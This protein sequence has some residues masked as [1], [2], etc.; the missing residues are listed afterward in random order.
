MFESTTNCY[1]IDDQSKRRKTETDYSFQHIKNKFNTNLNYILDC[2]KFDTR[3]LEALTKSCRF[4][5][6][7]NIKNC[8]EISKMCAVMSSCARLRELNVAY[9]TNLSENDIIQTVGKLPKLETLTLDCGSDLRRKTLK[10][11]AKCQ[12]HLHIN[13]AQSQFNNATTAYEN[14]DMS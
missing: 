11:I 12:P 14:N 2:W 10:H 7:L 6:K 5:E 1:P 9:C 3:G 13:I 4:L 8:S